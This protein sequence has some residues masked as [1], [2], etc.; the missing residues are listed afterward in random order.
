MAS[1]DGK[2]W[3]KL[4]EGHNFQP[5]D[6]LVGSTECQVL[7]V[8]LDAVRLDCRLTRREAS[9]LERVQVT[10]DPREWSN[11]FFEGWSEYWQREDALPQ[12]FPWRPLLAHVPRPDP[13]H[14]APIQYE[15]WRTALAHAKVSSMRG[16]CGWSVGELRLLPRELVEPL[17]RIFQK[18]EHGG[19]WPVQLRQWLLVLLRKDDG[20]P[21]WK[22]V[23]P[24]SVASVVYRVWARIR[25]R[26]L[27]AWC[28]LSALPTVGPRLSTRSLW[29]FVSDFVAEE[30]AS[31]HAPTGLVLDIVKAFNVLR[32][33]LVHDVMVHL[34]APVWLVQAWLRALEGMERHVLVAGTVFPAAVSLRRSNAG[35]PEG[36]PMSVVAMYCMCRFFASHVQ[37]C[38]GVLPLTYADNWQVIALQLEPLRQ[39]LPQVDD[40][41][42]RCSL[43]IAPEKCWMWS[44]GKQERRALRNTMLGTD[45]VPVRLQ[46]VDLGADLPYC[47][48]RAAA[49]RNLRV[50]AGHR[51]LQRARGLP[52]SKWHKSRLVL[53]GIWPQCLHGSETC[54]VPRSVLKRLRT[55]AKQGVSP[56]LACSVGSP[57]LV[58]PEFCLLL[59]RIRLFRLMWR[60]FPQA[61]DRMRKGLISLRSA[62]GA[63]SYL[64]SKQLRTWQWVVQGLWVQDDDGRRFHLVSTSLKAVKRIL[65]T[66]WMEMVGSNIAHRKSCEGVHR[67]DVDLSKV[68]TRFPLGDRALLL[69]QLTGVTY[70]RDCLSHVI[71]GHVSSACPLCGE[72]D[73]RLH[74]AKY[75]KATEEM[76][77]IF[78]RA[79]DG[80]TLP[81][82]TW[83]YGI[84]DEAP[85]LRAWQAQLCKVEFPQILLSLADDRQFVFTDGSCLCPKRP[86]LRLSGGAVIL[87]HAT[88]AYSLVWSGIVPGIDQSSYRA[89]LLALLVAVATFRK[90]TVF[91]D[92]LTVVRIATG[93]L[94]MDPVRR[95]RHLPLEHRDLWEAFCDHCQSR[96]W[97]ECILRWVK[98]HR[99]PRRLVGHNRL[100]A[101]F[102]GHA[103]KEAR[104]VVTDLARCDGYRDLFRY[105]DRCTGLA[106]RLAEMHVG[107][108]ALFQ[109]EPRI[110]RTVPSAHVFEVVGHGACLGPL[111][112]GA[113][114]HDGFGRALVGWLGSL[115]WYPSA[116]GGWSKVSA[117]ELLWQ[118][119]F[120]TGRLPPF[121][122]EGR[123]TVAD[124][125][126]L[127]G[128]GLPS[129]Q[130]LYR[131]WVKALRAIEGL[132]DASV[133][134]DSLSALG[135]S[136]GGFAL[137][138]RVPLHPDVVHDLLALFGR[139]GSTAAL[140]FPAFW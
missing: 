138:G 101:I 118:F 42:R 30:A 73:S 134:A 111:D 127:D 34:G 84:W 9:S 22:T 100:L 52:C 4:G 130:A 60:D 20:I 140:R 93:L 124:D 79:L 92:N 57:Q 8:S 110:P 49:K 43:P 115:R 83:A 53:T 59:Q 94:K 119:T 76:R 81:D 38:P 25:T 109:C 98:A 66:T 65:E 46:A 27:L 40:F 68:W 87:A 19:Q 44:M 14:L 50:S 47:R 135:A 23:Q 3:I 24:I 105:Y 128:F 15:D 41:L 139:R 63:V 75:C 117:L 45:K 37:L 7:E 29:G 102:N 104:K 48:K 6:L 133:G 85:A 26:Q 121:W 113:Q 90:V 13:L 35:V 70:T 10:L 71:D 36:D 58:D 61:R 62:V 31:G 122:F 77:D 21:T 120:D 69:A 97:G 5:G 82:H 126:V 78:V 86:N 123:W 96:V 67:I 17:L 129:M 1:L 132:P 18:C 11:A 72:T 116:R 16:T 28:Q 103:D 55:L 137:D 89:E 136:F 88:G 2:Q 125:S 54:D 64:L 131:S 12:D 95:R 80:F 112:A 33:P 51:R 56:W 39:V 99:D 114:V 108:A 106:T 91:C 74:R 107:M 32:R